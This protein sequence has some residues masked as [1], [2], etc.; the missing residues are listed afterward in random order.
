VLVQLADRVERFEVTERRWR[1]N[2]ALHGPERL[3]V[4]VT[5]A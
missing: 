5:P 4:V 2:N 3:D 1:R